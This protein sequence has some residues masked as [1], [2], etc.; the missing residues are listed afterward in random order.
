M[1]LFLT[2][3][4]ALLAASATYAVGQTVVRYT[5]RWWYMRAALKPC[6]TC[7]HPKGAHMAQGT[8]LGQPPPDGPLP[9]EMSCMVCRQDASAPFASFGEGQT[10]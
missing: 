3:Y 5:I 7:A 10:F 8:V 2:I 4:A 1:S 6:P 9:C